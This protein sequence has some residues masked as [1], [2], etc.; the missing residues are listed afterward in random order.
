MAASMPAAQL[1]AIMSSNKRVKQPE[2]PTTR[3]KADG[4]T[5]TSRG[6]GGT[7]GSATVNSIGSFYDKMINQESVPSFDELAQGIRGARKNSLLSSTLR[8]QPM[9]YGAGV[10]SSYI[11]AA[12]GMLDERSANAYNAEG[13][14]L[15]DKYGAKFMKRPVGKAPAMN[16]WVGKRLFE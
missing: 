14:A 10:M 8:D 16:K 13:E 9:G 3:Y 15:I 5:V 4:T 1:G 12:T 11:N 7:V 6:S 2:F